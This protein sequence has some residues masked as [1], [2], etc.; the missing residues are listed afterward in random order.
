MRIDATANAR[1]PS[2][3]GATPNNP[4]RIAKPA[5]KP[6]MRPMRARPWAMFAQTKLTTLDSAGAPLTNATARLTIQGSAACAN[7]FFMSTAA[8]A[9]STSPSVRPNR[10]H[11]AISRRNADSAARDSPA[12]LTK[13]LPDQTVQRPDGMRLG[14]ER[15]ARAFLRI[16]G[17]DVAVQPVAA[18]GDEAFKEQRGGDRPGER[19]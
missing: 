18:A 7:V 3:R 13:A 2:A 14:A 17:I 1:P 10:A 19:R 8:V 12:R 5:C 16:P 15:S 11:D 6:T 9:P 4:T